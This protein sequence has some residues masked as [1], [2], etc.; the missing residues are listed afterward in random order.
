MERQELLN[1]LGPAAIPKPPAPPP[2]PD[3]ANGEAGEP[4]EGEEG[5]W[6]DAPPPIPELTEPPEREIADRPLPEDPD[7]FWSGASPTRD[8]EIEVRIPRTPGAVAARLG[9][10]PFWRGISNCEAEM[11]RIYRNASIAG[12]DVYLGAGEVDESDEA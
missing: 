10:F 1:A 8:E 5:E 7:L 6:L 9:G 2:P 4:G 3:Y 12:L 11:A